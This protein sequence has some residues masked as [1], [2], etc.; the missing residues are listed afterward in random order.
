MPGCTE[1]LIA[2]C[3][4][5]A[6]RTN[7]FSKA[8]VDVL[9]EVLHDWAI[10]QGKEYHLRLFFNGEKVGGFVIFG[11]IPMTECAWDI[12]WIAVD[13]ELQGKGIGKSLMAQVEGEAVKRSGRAILRIET[14]GKPGYSRQRSFYKSCGFEERGRIEDFYCSG[15]DLVIYAKRICP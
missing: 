13:S 8:E 1:E 11:M 3:L 15:D 10:S 4:D 9:E 5:I 7:A 14:S 12:Y 2:Q 6:H